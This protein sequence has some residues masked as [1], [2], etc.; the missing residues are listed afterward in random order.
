MDFPGAIGILAPAGTPDDRLARW[1]AAMNAA[2]TAPTIIEKLATY[3]IEP[4]IITPDQ[5]KAWIAADNL[6]FREAVSDA[7]LTPQ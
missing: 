1:V 3:A 7:G 5:L 4:T 2:A 6:K